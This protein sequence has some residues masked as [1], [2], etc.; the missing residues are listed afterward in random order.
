VSAQVLVG[1]IGATTVRLALA[2]PGRRP[3]AHVAVAADAHANL[4]EAVEAGLAALAPRTRPRHA[5]LALA[6]PVI[7]DGFAFTNR[8]AWAFS[9]AA[10]CR[11]LGLERLTLVNDLAALALAL[12][13]AAL[14]EADTVPLGGPARPADPTAPCAVLGSGTGFGVAALVRCEG[15]AVAVAGEGGHAG[16]AARNQAE[17]KILRTLRDRGLRPTPDRLLSG[18]G[19]CLLYAAIAGTEADAAPAAAEIARARHSDPIAARTLDCFARWLGGFAGDVVLIL[20]ARG[21]AFIG[22]GVVP[23]LGPAFPVA[24]FRAGFEDK[25]R[26]RD[27]MAAIPTRLVVSEAAVLA[28][29]LAAA[30]RG[31]SGIVTV[32]GGR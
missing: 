19:L 2:E 15:E 7:G 28:G 21:G 9:A 27:Y 8:P 14:G 23:A 6:G 31:G 5:A 20:G 10:L 13:L 32:T 12:G 17:A 22:G 30:G 24:T 25:G 16:L 26:F 1:D 29:A 11:T 4:A 3:G 18:P